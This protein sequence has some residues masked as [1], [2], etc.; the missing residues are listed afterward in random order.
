MICANWSP[1][2]GWSWMGTCWATSSFNRWMLRWSVLMFGFSQARRRGS[3]IRRRQRL[4]G[5]LN[6]YYRAAA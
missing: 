5:M 6:Y 3:R 1:G 2:P 4:G